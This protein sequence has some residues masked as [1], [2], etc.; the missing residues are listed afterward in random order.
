MID[1]S[2]TWESFD[3]LRSVTSLPIIVKGI[4]TAE[5]AR[6]AVQHGVQG[7][8]VSNHGGRQLDGAPA[9]VCVIHLVLTFSFLLLL[10]KIIIIKINTVFLLLSD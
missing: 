8:L 6:L 10:Y 9:T 1:S 5:D 7:I 2:V 4:L 3:W